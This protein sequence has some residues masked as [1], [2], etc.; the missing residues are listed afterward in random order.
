LFFRTEKN[1]NP[2]LT[3]SHLNVSVTG[4]RA[5]G[6]PRLALDERQSSNP[7]TA[8]IRPF[9]GELGPDDRPS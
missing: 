4:G 7:V 6:G 5:L 2:S 9:S 1:K 8:V 3:P